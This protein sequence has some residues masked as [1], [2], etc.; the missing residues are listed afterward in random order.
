VRQGTD[1]IAYYYQSKVELHGDV[2]LEK[3]E[4]DMRNSGY[5][6]YRCNQ[7]E[8]E[9]LSTD[10]KA[11]EDVFSRLM[12][13]RLE[14][15]VRLIE[16]RLRSTATK[17]FITGGNDDPF[18]IEGILHSSNVIVDPEGEV[19]KIDD[20]REMV[21]LG[22]SNPTPWKTPRE[23]SEEVLDEKIQ[24]MITSVQDM[25]KCIFNLHVP[26]KDSQL[27]TC[28][29]LDDSVY[30]PRPI[31]VQGKTVEHGAGSSSVRLAIEKYQPLLGLHGHIHESR[32]AVRIGR[33]LCINPGS[34]YSEGILRGVVV[35]LDDKGV[36]AYQ[37]T[38]G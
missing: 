28:P 25:K 21:S 32:G 36:R 33:T 19:V 11:A 13:E 31:Q 26:P 3:Y 35:E 14:G 7:N 18:E 6:P 10:K 22:F 9:K 17:V 20:S 16:D 8:L 38:S 5:Y 29:K 27:D 23:V 24:A 1:A 2:E 30:P 34:E 4:N 15:W 12:K 37:L